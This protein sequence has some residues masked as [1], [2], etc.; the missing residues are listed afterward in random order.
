MRKAYFVAV[1]DAEAKTAA[2]ARL[3]QAAG[4]AAADA[5][6]PAAAASLAAAEQ[7]T[8]RQKDVLSVVTGRLLGEVK[9]EWRTPLDPPP[10]F[11]AATFCEHTR[12]ARRTKTTIHSST[13]GQVHRFKRAKAD[14]LRQ[15]VLDYVTLQI[16]YSKATEAQWAELVPDIE[17]IQVYA[18]KE[19]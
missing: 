9:Y 14:D 4:V 8:V 17:A 16:E 10:P 2:L 15:V 18:L 12:W 5:K 13:G 7:L 19:S 11:L 1:G 3:K 6:V